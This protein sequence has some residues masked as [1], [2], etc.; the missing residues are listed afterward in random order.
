MPLRKKKINNR[1]GTILKKDGII[2]KSKLELYCYTRLKE[3]G[4]IF[5]YEKYSFILQ[6]AFEFDNISI[7]MIKSRN[8]KSYRQQSKNIRAITYK[9]DFVNT[10]DKWIIECKGYPNDNFLIKWKMFKHFLWRN[11]LKID[12]YVPRNHKQIDETIEM[13]KNGRKI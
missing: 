10:K 8:D 12:L 5:D 2:F 3:E 7:E 6:P 4:L 11:S 9:P 1:S 13:I